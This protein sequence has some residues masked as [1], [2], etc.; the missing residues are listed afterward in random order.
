[1][2]SNYFMSD[3]EDMF[4]NDDAIFVTNAARQVAL[5]AALNGQ[6]ALPQTSGTA[7]R[8]LPLLTMADIMAPRSPSSVPPPSSVPHWLAAR[9]PSPTF[10]DDENRMPHSN[11]TADSIE[12]DDFFD[13]LLT[14]ADAAMLIDEEDNRMPH[15]NNTLSELS[16]DEDD[17]F[18]AIII[19]RAL[20]TSTPSSSSQPEV[21]LPHLSDVAV[22][23]SF[24]CGICLS[25]S[26]P[27][28]SHPCGNGHIFH[29][30]CLAEWMLESWKCPI[31]RGDAPLEANLVRV[32]LSVAPHSIDETCVQCSRLMRG[33]ESH[34]L[35]D[36]CGHRIHRRCALDVMFQHGVASNGNIVCSRCIRCKLNL[37]FIR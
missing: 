8:R 25:D 35:L 24:N 11:N 31:C 15:S 18:D 20:A 1:M 23:D 34:L 7:T 22:D 36:A 6:R 4:L 13:M 29:R 9:T 28:V 2:A 27:A 17:P 16:E 12:E 30:A 5:E 21:E 32:G 3:D 37:L 14:P 26:G 10:S 33:P 19:R